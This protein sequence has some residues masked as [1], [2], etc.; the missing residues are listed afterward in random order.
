MKTNVR[1]K[2][3]GLLSSILIIFSLLFLSNCK[4]HVEVFGIIDSVENCSP[5]YVVYFYPDAEYNTKDLEI[6]WD[7]G[8]GT[9]SHDKE[10][11]HIYTDYGVFTVELS[12][13]QK[14][15]F[16]SK[17]AILYLTEDSTAVYADWDYASLADSLWAPAYVEFQNYSL[18]STKFLWEFGTTEADTSNEK[19]PIF[20]YEDQGTYTTVLNAVC[21]DDTSKYSREMIIKPPPG[22]ILIN[23]VTIWMPNQYVGTDI[24]VKLWYAGHE[25]DQ[26][27]LAT[28]VTS[29]PITFV[30][31]H[32]LYWFNGTYNND[33]LEFELWSSIGDGNPEKI[34]GVESRDLQDEY[35]PT[36]IGR[37]DG[38]GFIFEA[39]LDYRD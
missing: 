18:H 9:T 22:D 13:R 28:A 35:Y 11:V 1:F 3:T 15:A 39:L 38:Y 23:E 29:F 36:I 7:F 14:E 19:N 37:D 30:L 12:I 16:D 25:E 26:S 34:F 27:S 2:L 31:T 8:D 24:W 4:G 6:T 17:S 32:N 33:L 5:P 21:N 10:P 20:I